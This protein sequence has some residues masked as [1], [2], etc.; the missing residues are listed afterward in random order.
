MSGTSGRRRA[1]DCGIRWS[2]ATLGTD[3]VRTTI[4]RRAAGAGKRT[5]TEYPRARLALSLL[6]IV[7]IGGGGGGGGDGDGG[8]TARGDAIRVRPLLITESSRARDKLMRQLSSAELL[9]SASRAFWRAGLPSLK[10]C[11][12]NLR[13]PSFQALH[14][15]SFTWILI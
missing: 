5:L 13:T 3:H 7:V 8:G 11:K 9:N 2:T 12:R 4:S 14:I 15:L 6:G 10:F 1:A